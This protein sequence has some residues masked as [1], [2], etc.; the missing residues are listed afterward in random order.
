MAKK[1]NLYI[2]Y[3]RDGEF[4]LNTRIEFPKNIYS[5]DDLY[6]NFP[7]SRFKNYENISEIEKNENSLLKKNELN[8]FGFRSEEFKK[9]HNEKHVVFSGCSYTFGTGVG[10]DD[11]WSK[12]TYEK[13]NNKIKC[14]GYFNLG[15]PGSSL[16][17]A[18]TDL[19][20]YF[21]EYGNPDIIFLNIPDLV[22]LY[23]FDKKTK[24][25]INSFYNEES[26]SVLYLLAYQYYFM[27]DQYC[28]ENNIQLYSFSWR[29]SEQE[30]TDDFIK[31]K[32]EKFDTFY[33]Y[34]INDLLLFVIGHKDKNKNT[35]FLDLGS[36][37]EHLGIS[38]HA[39]WGNFIHTKFL[40]KNDN[41]RN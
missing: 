10:F 30:D 13:I 1:E 35:K 25:I 28:K 3:C 32:I 4:S 26:K 24:K 22:R 6:L 17:H 11:T 8:N 27:L 23:S 41:L 36:D 37:G 20:K 12:V 33:N 2:N 16:F 31:S 19:F 14:S 18:I 38:Y 5:D 39:Y 21:K 15:V 40:E 9:T 34:S 7:I 29:F